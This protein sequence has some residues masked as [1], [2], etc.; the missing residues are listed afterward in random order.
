MSTNTPPAGTQAK[1][2]RVYV[3]IPKAGPGQG[4]RAPKNYQNPLVDVLTQLAV[5]AMC[6][7]LLI[8]PGAIIA[9]IVWNTY[10]EESYL[11]WLWATMFVFLE[12]IAIFIAV[13][14]WREALGLSSRADYRG[15]V[16]AA[17]HS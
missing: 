14:L 1:P 8:V 13:G 10:A 12:A 15:T 16:R 9:M 6:L 11:L 7:S 5:A 4:Y 3:E 2:E 17:P